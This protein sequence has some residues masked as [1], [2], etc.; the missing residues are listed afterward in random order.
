MDTNNG[1][2]KSFKSYS[3]FATSGYGW[4][5]DIVSNGTVL[6]ASAYSSCKLY[7]FN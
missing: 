1:N 2:Q 7:C 5:L 6:Y 4:L 3:G